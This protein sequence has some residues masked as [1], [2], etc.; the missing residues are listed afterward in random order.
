MPTWR[1]LHGI[2]IEASEAGSE[3]KSLDFLVEITKST[4]KLRNS[5]MTS[6]MNSGISCELLNI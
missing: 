6:K 5:V 2:N 4:Q 3:K 1:D